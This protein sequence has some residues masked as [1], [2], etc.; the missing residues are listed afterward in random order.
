[1]TDD[2]IEKLRKRFIDADEA[3]RS[4]LRRWD[5]YSE[6]D[7]NRLTPRFLELK[8]QANDAEIALRTAQAKRAL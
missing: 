4:L 8:R 6:E 2:E 1:L 3:F 5:V 7:R